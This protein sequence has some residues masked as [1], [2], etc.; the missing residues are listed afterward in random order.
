MANVNGQKFLRG[1]VWWCSKGNNEKDGFVQTTNRPHV[2]VSNNV[3]NK[4]APIIIAVPCTSEDKKEMETHVP[5]YFNNMVNT[6][7]CEQIKTL[8]T[9]DLVSYMLTLDDESM[10]KIDEALKIS[11]GLDGKGEEIHRN[12]VIPL[13]VAETINESNKPVVKEQLKVVNNKVNHNKRGR[14]W[15]L[16]EK[17]EYVQYYTKYGKDKTNEKYK[18]GN[19]TKQYYQRFLQLLAKED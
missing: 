6:V 2:I 15:T 18:T 12:N 10:S 8:N 17:R 13:K 14:I 3:G 4:F 7:L 1:Q 5:L 9:A 16:D 19:N 11:L